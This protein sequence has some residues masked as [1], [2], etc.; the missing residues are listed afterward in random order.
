MGKT[1]LDDEGE[2]EN[3]YS[4]ELY[5][6]HGCS[7]SDEEDIALIKTDR[8]IIPTESIGFICLP[9]ANSFPTN[10]KLFHTGWGHFEKMRRGASNVL[11]MA[12][13]EL[14]SENYCKYYQSYVNLGLS[15]Y[16]R[17]EYLGI[18]KLCVLSPRQ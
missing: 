18:K 16:E 10:R 11:Q 12:E 4:P 3:L 5:V 2:I 8:P 6:M 14:F 17:T 7:E 15:T 1:R 13:T 9:V